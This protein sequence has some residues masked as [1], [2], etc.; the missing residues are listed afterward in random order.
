MGILV[1]IWPNFSH[2]RKSISIL[3]AALEFDETAEMTF[4]ACIL[5][6]VWNPFFFFFSTR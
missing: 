3:F 4:A 1:A 6:A 5:Y 2:N